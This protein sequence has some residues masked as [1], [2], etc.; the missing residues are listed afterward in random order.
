MKEEKATSTGK[1]YIILKYANKSKRI[2]SESFD[3]IKIS[4][5]VYRKVQSFKS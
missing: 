1:Y 5:S 3:T 4:L 2:N